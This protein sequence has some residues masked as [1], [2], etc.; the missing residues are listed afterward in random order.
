MT[1]RTL[2]ENL[3]TASACDGLF[4]DP[5]DDLL[6]ANS[7]FEADDTERVTQLRND[8]DLGEA[9]ETNR[10]SQQEGD[11]QEPRASPVPPRSSASASASASASSH[12]PTPSSSPSQPDL[13]TIQVPHAGQHNDLS[14]QHD[15]NTNGH[16]GNQAIAASQEPHQERFSQ[17]V[18]NKG[19]TYAP[20][21]DPPRITT[22]AF[23]TLS[24]RAPEHRNRHPSNK[25]IL[26]DSSSSSTS[27]SSS[28]PKSNS[29]KDEK[30]NEETYYDLLLESEASWSGFSDDDDNDE[31]VTNHYSPH[32]RNHND[33]SDYSPHPGSHNE[34]E[35]AV[36]RE[37]SRDHNEHAILADMAGLHSDHSMPVGPTRHGAMQIPRSSIVMETSP[38]LRTSRPVQVPRTSLVVETSPG[39]RRAGGDGMLVDERRHIIERR[40]REAFN[41]FPEGE[42]AYGGRVAVDLF[43]SLK[44]IYDAGA[45]GS[46]V[47]LY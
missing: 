19:N 44:Q 26:F 4:A 14:P 5:T 16:Q 17:N 23:S 24:A 42:T 18:T 10:S 37:T 39:S 46:T 1:R 41:A 38:Y 45:R 27:S 35:Q 25:T 22:S 15:V 8:E 9:N 32:S 12:S 43:S 28:S 2:S 21:I 6:F 29:G 47:S 3:F 13:D 11:T 40:N 30:E 31:H 20:Q 33:I 36:P 7:Q 34:H